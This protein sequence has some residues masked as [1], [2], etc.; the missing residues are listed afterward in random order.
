MSISVLEAASM[1]ATHRNSKTIDVEDINMILSKLWF[2]FPYNLPLMVSVTLTHATAPF[3]LEKKLGVDLT[4]FTN[5]R[6]QQQAL[7]QTQAQ[8]Q[9]VP[10]GGQQMVAQPMLGQQQQMHRQQQMPGQQ[11][12]LIGQQQQLIG[13]QQQMMGQQQQRPGQQQQ[14]MTG[15]QQQM[16]GQ[17][18]QIIG[19]QQQRPGQQQQMPGQHQQM[20]GQQQQVHGQHVHALP[21]AGHQGVHQFGQQVG[22]Q[23]DALREA[24]VKVEPTDQS[25][26]IAQPSPSIQNSGSDQQQ[27]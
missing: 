19:Q 15:Q 18:Q 24:E 6:L 9:A 20:M 2:D 17:Q 21:T 11:Q 3:F 4:A 10:V 12:K 7:Q 23:S 22:Q 8:Q 5:A 13:Q 27:A 26:A 16:M 1:L 25:T 14:Q